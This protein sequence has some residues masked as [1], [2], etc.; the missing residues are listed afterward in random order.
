SRF[1]AVAARASPGR[2][3]RRLD[4]G[5]VARPA[6]RGTLIQEMTSMRTFTF[7]DASAHKFWNIDLAGK[8]FTVQFGRIGSAGQ[9]QVKTFPDEDKARKEHDKLIA[10]KLKKGYQETTPAST[11][12][13]A[14]LRE[15]L[16]QALVEDPDDLA[17]HMA[18]A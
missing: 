16:E 6:H 2:G 12:A 13:P 1:P 7:S 10:E 9:T 15:T 3:R 14:S 4:A 17:S 18:H 11:P 8:S 5:R